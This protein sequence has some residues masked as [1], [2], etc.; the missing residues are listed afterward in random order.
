[1]K[2]KIII[3]LVVAS[4]IAVAFIALIASIFGYNGKK[5]L[6]F[7]DVKFNTYIQTI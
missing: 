1:M 3:L 5:S 7:E 6:D 2:K 4:V